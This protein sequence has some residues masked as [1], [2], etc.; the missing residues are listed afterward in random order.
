MRKAI[1]TLAPALA[2]AFAAGLAA[3]GPTDGAENVN[4]VPAANR[5]ASAT[6]TTNPAGPPTS[7]A[8]AANTSAPAA[9]ATAASPP[10]HGHDPA[11]TA[12]SPRRITVA[13]AR[14][15]FERN[16]AVFVDVRGEDAFRTG[17]IR[18]A[19][20]IP[21]GAE[22]QHVDKLPKNKLIITYCA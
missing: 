3:C 4:A 18:G 9:A 19:L 1:L 14:A 5:A 15:A 8:A 12:D 7:P 13:E 2:L 6:T 16:Q 17:H 20:S 10:D 21:T 22:A 11:V